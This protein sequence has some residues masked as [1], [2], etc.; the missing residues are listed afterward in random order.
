MSGITGIPGRNY[1][2]LNLI[3]ISEANLIHNY[4][5]L[6]S[7]ERNINIAPVLKSNSYGHDLVITGKIAEKL[8]PSFVCVDSLY[9][10]YALTNARIATPILIMGK[11]DPTSL[12][13]K[14]LPYSFTVFSRDEI[15]AL[16]RYQPNAKIH[17][18]VDTGMHREGI[19][20]EDFKEFISFIQDQTTLIIDGLMSHLAMSDQPQ[21]PMTQQQITI[22]QKAQ[23]ILKSFDIQPRWIHI[24]NSSALINHKE[25]K[26]KLGNLAR[27]GK[28]FY[29]Y[30]P[31]NE[32]R[33]LKPALSLKTHIGQIKKLK[34]GE[35]V[36]YDFTYIAMK[37]MTIAVLPIGY[38]DGVDR[39]LSNVGVV[40]IRNRY[41]PIIGRVSMNITT[42]DISDL[43]NP[44]IGDEVI[45][46]SP[47]KKAKNSIINAAKTANTI[48]H[49]MLIHL[50]PSTK[51][52][53]VDKMS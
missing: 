6:N 18:F 16:S 20:I 53:I 49:E 26:D 3:E 39:R 12:H 41:C 30:D 45:I 36:G 48:A 28:A 21:N 43:K 4:S 47:E 50:N 34:K 37:D 13:T 40:S 19:R 24:A 51:R 10:A 44:E 42:I 32:D 2:P 1:S 17:V 11:V 46:Y 38:N 7:L 52:I 8:N 25:Y 31:E 15:D 29:G 27:I 22:F 35:E 5:Y 23:E 14:K 9:E 33:N